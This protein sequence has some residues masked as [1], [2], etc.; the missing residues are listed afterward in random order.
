MR[1]SDCSARA[2]MAGAVELSA[3]DCADLESNR[4][5][6]LVA[7]VVALNHIDDFFAD[8]GLRSAL[9]RSHVWPAGRQGAPHPLYG[10]LIRQPARVGSP[11]R[12]MD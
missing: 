3:Q 10:T 6:L 4:V 2:V 5:L 8:V 12:E 1:L 11:M 7:N 9:R